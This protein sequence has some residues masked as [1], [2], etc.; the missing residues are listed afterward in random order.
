MPTNQLDSFRQLRQFCDR[1]LILL[2]CRARAFFFVCL[3]LAGNCLRQRCEGA[4][5]E[6][7]FDIMGLEDDERDRLLDMPQS[8]AS[9]PSPLGWVCII[10][11]G[12]LRSVTNRPLLFRFVFLFFACRRAEHGE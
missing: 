4:G 1:V 6:T 7:P 10:Y 11:G 3:D 5:V 2:V 12:I 8:K 9:G